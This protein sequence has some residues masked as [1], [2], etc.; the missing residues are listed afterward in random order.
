MFYKFRYSDPLEG[1]EYKMPYFLDSD[2]GV[3][4]SEQTT[5]IS[6]KIWLIR[7][8]IDIELFLVLRQ[9][10]TFQPQCYASSFK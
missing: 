3:V 6:Y 7:N 10:P 8:L 5:M 4:H 9:K 2:K 1:I